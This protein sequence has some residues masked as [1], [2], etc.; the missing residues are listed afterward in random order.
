MSF[1]AE[2]QSAEQDAFADTAAAPLPDQPQ[3]SAPPPQQD[4][5]SAAAVQHLTDK[6]PPHHRRLVLPRSALSRP[7]FYQSVRVCLELQVQQEDCVWGSGSG[8]TD[9]SGAAF[10]VCWPSCCQRML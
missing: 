7:A 6:V 4:A 10:D 8:D 9:A 5:A 3:A 2:L 1:A